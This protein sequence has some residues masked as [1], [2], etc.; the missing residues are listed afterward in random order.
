MKRMQRTDLMVGLGASLAVTNALVGPTL[1]PVENGSCPA[2]NFNY[3][4]EESNTPATGAMRNL[5]IFTLGVMSGRC[6]AGEVQAT[7]TNNV[8]DYQW[9]RVVPADAAANMYIISLTANMDPKGVVN[10]NDVTAFTIRKDAGVNGIHSGDD[11]SIAAQEVNTG[12]ITTV[13]Q[14]FATGESYTFSGNTGA[15]IAEPQAVD[16]TRLGAR[17]I[18]EALQG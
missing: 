8:V 10:P 15:S 14:P 1:Q 12:I 2:V 5:G 17:I 4:P 3:A 7:I 9:T 6:R 18:D 16:I 13:T 11:V